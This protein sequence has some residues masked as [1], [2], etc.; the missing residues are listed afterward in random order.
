MTAKEHSLNGARAASTFAL[1]LPMHTFAQLPEFHRVLL[2][3]YAQHAR[4]FVWREQHCNPYI[5]LVSEVMLQQTQTARVEQKLP[6][7][8]EQ[9]PSVHALAEADN[10]T[11]IRAWQ[12]MGYNNRAIRLRDCARAIAE[13]HAGVVPTT[14][15]ELLALPG[16]GLYTASAVLAFAYGQ[17]VPVVD[18]NVGRVYSRVFARMATTAELLP[19]RELRT[20]AAEVFPADKSSVWHQA[21]MDLSA[22]YCTARAPKCSAC[23][24]ANVCCSALGMAEEKKRKRPEPSWRGEPNRIWRGRVVEFLRTVEH[25][26][27]A[28]VQR[29]AAHLFANEAYNAES[30]FVQWLRQLL[31]GLQRDSLIA[32]EHEAVFLHT[33]LQLQQEKNYGIHT[34]KK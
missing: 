22:Q 20:L 11:I 4:V 13:R 15:D 30:E 5:V 6:Q 8:L 10:A 27:W 23:P 29:V 34:N 14:M 1:F 33:R 21:V 25:G 28:T 2:A 12:G 26:T 17:S 18:V 24:V 19:E 3:W 7:F 16:I 9:F 31:T 32:V